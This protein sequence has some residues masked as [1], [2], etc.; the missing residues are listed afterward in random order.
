MWSLKFL[1]FYIAEPASL[2]LTVSTNSWMYLCMKVEANI[3]NPLSECAVRSWQEKK[4][5][6]SIHY[7][8][9]PLC[10][11]VLA[12]V[13]TH[14]ALLVQWFYGE[15]V[16][17]YVNDHA[18]LEPVGGVGCPHWLPILHG[19]PVSARPHTWDRE[20]QREEGALHEHWR[21][22]VK[23]NLPLSWLHLLLY[24][25]YINCT[26]KLNN[27]CIH[28]SI[29]LHINSS[30]RCFFW[31]GGICFIYPVVYWKQQQDLLQ[32]SKLCHYLCH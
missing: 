1:T 7:P 30:V 21:I 4:H 24:H 23:L 9:C 22:L 8:R 6:L 13:M 11:C 25:T 29:R 32:M 2:H 28:W 26:V 15:R 31:G 5:E 17:S 27:S 20:R 14:L 16:G 12:C 18:Q 3:W 19:L 10:V